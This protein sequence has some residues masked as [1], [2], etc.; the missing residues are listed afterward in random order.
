MQQFGLINQY[1]VYCHIISKFSLSKTQLL[2]NYHVQSRTIDVFK[3]EVCHVPDL[4]CAEWWR[5]QWHYDV[6][7]DVADD[8]NS[9]VADDMAAT[10]GSD[11]AAQE[12]S[13]GISFE[14]KHH[15]KKS[16]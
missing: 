15:Q 9:D 1:Y 10:R 5:Q 2:L 3:G 8:T 7:S 12:E 6:S 16:T 13:V 11:V 14:E 4:L